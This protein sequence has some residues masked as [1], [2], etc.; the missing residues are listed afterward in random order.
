MVDHWWQTETG[1]PIA[2]NLRGLEPMELKPGSP[3]VPVPGYQIEILDVD[4]SQLPRGEEGAIVIK[5]PLPPGCLQTLWNDD[6]RFRESY[7]S[8]YEGYY[9][10]GDGGYLDE[11]DYLF[12]MGRTDDV[13]NVAG[14][15][16]STGSMEE[17][18]AGHPDVAECAVIGVA[19]QMKGQVPRGFVV[20]KAG[21][22][23][24]EDELGPELVAM[25]RD[26]VGAVASFKNV[27]VVPALPKTRSGKVLRKTMRN[28]ADGKDE[29]VP[30][31]IDDASV[32]DT[33]RPVLQK[34]PRWLTPGE[35]ECGSRRTPA[36]GPERTYEAC[37]QPVVGE[38]RAAVADVAARGVPQPAGHDRVDPVVG[39]HG[40]DAGGDVRDRVEDALVGERREHGGAEGRVD[41]LHEALRRRARGG[42]GVPAVDGVG[43]AR[44]LPHD[45]LLDARRQL[46]GQA[47]EPE[48]LLD[49]AVE[50]VVVTRRVGAAELHRPVLAGDRHRLAEVLDARRGRLRGG[51]QVGGGHRDGGDVADGPRAPGGRPAGA[52]RRREGHLGGGELRGRRRLGVRVVGRVQGRDG[53][54]D[55]PGGDRRDEDPAGGPGG[56]GARRGAGGG[57][58]RVVHGDAGRHG[59]G[60]STQGRRRAGESGRV[61]EGGAGSPARRTCRDAVSRHSGRPSPQG[62]A[63]TGPLGSMT[64]GGKS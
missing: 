60:R 54:D 36:H 14:H 2:A 42:V 22:E 28:I 37:T 50:G 56:E 47:H 30:S 12:V 20:L 39:D 44:G 49:L 31:T 8:R 38:L 33:L 34:G 24:T 45:D 46:L 1:W 59:A 19:D 21:V 43:V 18:L 17:V 15:R 57:R 63:S 23:R 9:L 3:S 41:E 25:V 11:D 51:R 29:A 5:L 48:R 6:E 7:M 26:Q 4:G 55:G 40:A 61:A 32:L 53:G 64:T 27:A 62:I 35:Q 16:L 10:T 52:L 13:I 58:A